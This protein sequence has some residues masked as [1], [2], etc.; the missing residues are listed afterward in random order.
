MT[1]LTSCF[2]LLTSLSSSMI[3]PAL[4]AISVDLDI[5]NGT[6]ELMIISIFVLAF[7]IGPLIF[8]PLSEIY[9][10][11]W[12][13]QST[14]LFYLIFN[15]ACGA[16]QTTAQLIVFRFLSGLSGSATLAVC[17]IYHDF[18]SENAE[19]GSGWGRHSCRRMVNR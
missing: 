9:G 6:I 2:T 1:V 8:A 5:T 19:S 13:L 4:L 15:T 10:R 17:P 18:L 11:K 7:G 12:V 16:S 3:S 14:N